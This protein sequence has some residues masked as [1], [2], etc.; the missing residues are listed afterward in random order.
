MVPSPIGRRRGKGG[1]VSLRP[2]LWAYL[3][4]IALLSAGFYAFPGWHMVIWSAIGVV[5]AAAMAYGVR[6]NRPRRYLPWCLL[7]ISTLTFAAG[8]PTYH[9]LTTVPRQ[10]RAVPSAAR[11]ISP[12]TR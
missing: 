5:S 9:L 7:A 4:G 8:G 1:N 6:R 10:S 11:A 2:L 3:I 12:G